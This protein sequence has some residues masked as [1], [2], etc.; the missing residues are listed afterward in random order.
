MNV[1]RTSLWIAAVLVTCTWLGAAADEAPYKDSRL[2]LEDRV[3]DLL[4]RMTVEEKVAQLNLVSVQGLRFADPQAVP[5]LLEKRFKGLSHGVLDIEFGSPYEVV[6]QRICCSQ[7][8]ARLK[9]R[10]GIPFLPIDETLHGVLSEGAT[11]F[12]QTIAQGRNL[13]PRTDQGDGR[14]NCP[15]GQ[16]HGA[17]AG[18]G[19]DVGTRS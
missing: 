18:A 9:T 14:G 5:D 8:Y 3:K 19:P 13:E 2:P 15:R 6:A 12:P 1:E 16:Q 10:L 17:G 11:I 7:Q 4:A